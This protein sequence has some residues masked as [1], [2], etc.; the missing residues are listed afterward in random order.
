MMS[1]LIGGPI[2][3]PESLEGQ[4]DQ[5]RRGRFGM[6]FKCDKVRRRLS[7]EIALPGVDQPI[8]VALRQPEFTDCVGQ[9]L[10][11]RVSAHGAPLEGGRDVLSPPLQT[12]LPEH[13]LGDGLRYP[14]NLVVEGVK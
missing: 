13:R 2:T 1:R 7:S 9:S 3:N 5:L 4:V 14:C 12:D 10:H 6:A 11:N 8:E